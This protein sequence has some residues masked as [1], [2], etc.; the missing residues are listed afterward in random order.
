[1]SKKYNVA[2]VGATGLV[3]RTM[4]KVLEEK[5]FPINN[6]SLFASKRSIGKKIQY[7]SNEI[8]VQELTKDSFKNIDI[9]L[10]SA[11][12]DVSK[13]FAPKAVDSNCIVIDNSSYWRMN[14]NVPLIVPE[15]NSNVINSHKGIIANPNCSTI[16]LVIP[17]YALQKHFNLKR[18]VISTYQAISGAGQKGINLFQQESSNKNNTNNK[19]YNNIAFHDVV[20]DSVFTSEEIKMLNETRKILS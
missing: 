11:G 17:L 8:Q 18:V 7:L 1:M 16:Q 14:K 13:E 12:T 6:L 5:K 15:V 20:G 10:F 3:G 2:V 4:V 19:I 9:A